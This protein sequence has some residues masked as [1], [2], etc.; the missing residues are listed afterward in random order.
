MS[1]RNAFFSLVLL[2]LMSFIFTESLFAKDEKK[3][4]IPNV[5][6]RLAVREKREPLGKDI[7]ILTFYCGL[8]SCSLAKLSL[9]ECRPHNN[10]MVFIPTYSQWATWLGT[11]D[12]EVVSSDTLKITIFQ[13]TRRTLPAYLH[14]SFIP[15]QP[16]A[17]KITK[18]QA[19]GFNKTSIHDNIEYIP[20]LGPSHP[21]QLDC[22]LLVP[23]LEE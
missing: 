7:H 20:I 22:P 2:E 12:I 17:E 3:L 13:G 14:I 4:P 1:V 9:N 8:G 15:Q 23:G 21:E 18:F 11:L 19:I 6:F 10:Q 16:F 5:D